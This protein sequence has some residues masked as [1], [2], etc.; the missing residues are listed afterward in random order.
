MPR[1]Q[2]DGARQRSANSIAAIPL[3]NA[4]RR[5]CR[6]ENQTSRRHRRQGQSEYPGVGL[7]RRVARRALGGRQTR[8]IAGPVRKE[9]GGYSERLV[10]RLSRQVHCSDARAPALFPRI[11][12]GVRP[13]SR[14]KPGKFQQIRPKTSSIRRQ[15]TNQCSRPERDETG[16][17]INDLG[18]RGSAVPAPGQ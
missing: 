10:A 12:S 8:V 15:L 16:R 9:P 1:P 14:I 6:V 7:G 17:L 3:T 5:R 4:G 18:W 11:C 2:R 13:G